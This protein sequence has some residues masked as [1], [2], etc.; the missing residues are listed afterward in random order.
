MWS[1]FL[2][3]AQLRS[4]DRTVFQALNSRGQDQMFKSSLNYIA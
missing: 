2:L 4:N 1:N 3:R